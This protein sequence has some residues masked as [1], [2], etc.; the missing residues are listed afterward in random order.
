MMLKNVEKYVIL[1][2][3]TFFLFVNDLCSVQYPVSDAYVGFAN[4]HESR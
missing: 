1:Y 3:A 4:A 2:M